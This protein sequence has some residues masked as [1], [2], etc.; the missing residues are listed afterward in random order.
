MKTAIMLFLLC[1]A[2]SVSSVGCTEQIRTRA[3]GGSAIIEAPNC[4]KVV[5]AT[6]KATDL[7]LLVR[8]MTENEKPEELTFYESSSWGIFEG[9]IAIREKC[10]K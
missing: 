9:S 10:D 8:P 1:A 6:W 3:Y 5:N 7:W 4:K 2:V